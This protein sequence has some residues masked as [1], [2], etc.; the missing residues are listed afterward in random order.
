M[1]NDTAADPA[2]RAWELRRHIVEFQQAVGAPERCPIPVIVA[3][4]GLVLGLGID[5][6]GYCDVRYTASNA[7]FS[8]KEVDIGLAADIGTLATLPKATGNQSLLNE[9]AFSTKQFSAA[10]AEKLGFVSKVVP[11]GRD[12]VV[13]EALTLAQTIASKSPYAVASTKHL[14][15][16]SRDHTVTENL[17]YTATWNGAGLQAKVG[18]PQFLQTG[19]VTHRFPQD[20]PDS[21]RAVLRKTTA[22]YAPLQKSKL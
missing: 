10:E 6:M 17:S 1:F 16:H 13:A 15:L 14:L 4:H 8:I 7:S 2:R 21:L 11:G 12:E 3:V 18:Q 9:L 20:T 19:L 5:I 22:E